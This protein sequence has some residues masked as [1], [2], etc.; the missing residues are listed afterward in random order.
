M[1]GIYIHIPFCRKACYYCDFHFSTYHKLIAPMFSALNRELELQ[2]KYPGNEQIHT[3]Y[4]GGG[5]PS[6][7]EAH[8]IEKLLVTIHDHYPVSRNA[9]IT[10]EANP[11]DLNPK[12]LKELKSTGINRLSIG[13]QSFQ[14]DILRKLNRIHSAEE[15]LKSIRAAEKAGFYNYNIDLIYAISND[16]DSS[17]KKDLKIVKSLL[18]PHISTYHL[19]IEPGTVFGNWVKKGIMNPAK[20]DIG[21]VEYET[22]MNALSD[23]GYDHYEISNFAQ[24]GYISLHN[25]NYWKNIPYL[26][27]GPSAHSYNLVSRQYN[28]SNNSLYIKSI[29]KNIIPA[30]ID[31]LTS[32]DRINECIMTGLRTKW[33]C[34]FTNIK[35][36]S[37]I[38]LLE[39]HREYINKLLELR[40]VKLEDGILTLENKGKLLADKISQDLFFIQKL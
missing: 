28:I 18:P 29:K 14:D 15:A 26:G 30:T 1:A 37:G 38:D 24:P 17:F 34:D 20:E 33:G 25:S 10:L 40:M 32:T 7:V 8:H 4:F 39:N 27:I 12:K 19:T 2:N 23:A 6:V 21:A 35:N 36:M 13:I 22:I 31:Y 9:E 16:Q 11:D 3:I 5:T